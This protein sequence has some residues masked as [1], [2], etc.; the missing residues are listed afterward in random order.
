MQSTNSSVDED[1]GPKLCAQEKYVSHTERLNQRE[2]WEGDPAHTLLLRRK[3]RVVCAAGSGKERWPC[4]QAADL[5]PA[6][7][8]AAVC[9]EPGS[10]YR[11]LISEYGT[12]QLS[13]RQEWG[14]ASR[15]R[16]NSA[17]LLP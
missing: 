8:S 1:E 12:L 7:S 5:W 16:A 6:V 15:A 4:P 14:T 3:E 11:L 17:Y 10:L 13:L 2:E 9:H